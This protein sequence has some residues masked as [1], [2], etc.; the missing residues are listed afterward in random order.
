MVIVTIIMLCVTSFP[1]AVFGAGN[2]L[3]EIEK[4]DIEQVI[5][6]SIDDEVVLGGMILTDDNTIVGGEDDEIDEDET[7]DELEE[8]DDDPIIV[9]RIFTRN[10]QEFI[11]L[12]NNSG[13][14]IQ[15]QSLSVEWFNSALTSQGV[16]SKTNKLFL[17]DSF[18]LVKQGGSSLDSD[19]SWGSSTNKI[20]P[21]GGKI[22]VGLDGEILSTIC[23]GGVNETSCTEFIE[24]KDTEIFVNEKCV[25]ICAEFDADNRFGGI[26]DIDSGDDDNNNG[27]EFN[28]CEYISINEI[29]FSD[30]EKFIEIINTTNKIID[31]TDCALRRGNGYIYMDGELKPSEI[32]SFSV[33][34]S[35]LTQ[36]NGSVN[37]YVYDI[38]QKKNVVTVA[39][40]SRSGTSYAWLTVDGTEGWFSTYAMTPGAENIYQQFQTCEVGKHIN[41]ATGNCVKDP[42]PPA[43]CAEGQY[44]NPATGRC[45]KLDS[46]K[47]LADC[48]EGQFR[49]PATNRCKKIASGD[50]LNPCAE[51]WERNPETNRCRKIPIGSEAAYA[52]GP[53]ANNNE[54]R[55]WAWI[56]TGGII[57]IM[58]IIAWQFRPEIGRFFGRIYGKVK[59]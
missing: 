3:L 11:Q 5:G 24:I 29:S 28:M 1:M 35:N 55:M 41:V 58:G 50:E 10:G 22:I 14:D 37:I 39:Y 13:S 49:N 42:D 9:S 52:V 2:D 19:S 48:A 16:F 18:V 45:K 26:I 7:V 56:A 4:D 33:L 31:L 25:D 34:D 59:K 12:H 23:W 8:K 57:V 43:E 40:K 54:S 32:K 6:E 15:F 44:R 17:A 20:T 21:S 47:T 38:L 53:I 36:T 51:G 30:P 27:T 46:E